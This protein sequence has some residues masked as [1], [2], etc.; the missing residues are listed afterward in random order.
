MWQAIKK[1]T[2]LLFRETVQAFV[3]ICVVSPILFLVLSAATGI[4]KLAW[5]YI[6]WLWNA[7]PF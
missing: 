2:I 6:V 7:L 4:G 5:L 3:K 1:E